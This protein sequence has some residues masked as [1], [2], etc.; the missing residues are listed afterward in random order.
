MKERLEAENTD[1]HRSV[2]VRP[3]RLP[4]SRSP[5]FNQML[6]EIAQVAPTRS[7]VLPLGETGTGKEVLADGST[8]FLDEVGEL[9]LELQK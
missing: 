7:T 2:A 8:L 3:G 9:P 5:G 6:E 1:L 4:A